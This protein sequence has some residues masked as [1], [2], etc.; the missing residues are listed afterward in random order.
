MNKQNPAK[1]YLCQYRGLLLRYR[2][3]MDQIDQ[4]EER[5]TDTSARFSLA[6]VQSGG[7]KDMVGDGAAAAVDMAGLLMDTA[8]EIKDRMAGILATIDS[9]V[10]DEMQKTILTKRY[11]SDKSWKEI[12]AEIGYEKS[13]V[14]ELHG[15]ALLRVNMYLEKRN[16]GGT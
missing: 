6:K 4:I 15:L 7:A 13:K 8:A 5:A 2:E 11:I 10:G 1:L 12:C 14:H 3:I 9:S 16:A